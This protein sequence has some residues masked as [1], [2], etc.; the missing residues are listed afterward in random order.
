MA[1]G[2]ELRPLSFLLSL[3]VPDPASARGDRSRCLCL[4]NVR[5]KLRA[6]DTLEAGAGGGEAGGGGADA[7]G[8]AP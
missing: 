1:S 5:P 7:G 3:K 2:M 6:Y 4:L 8:G